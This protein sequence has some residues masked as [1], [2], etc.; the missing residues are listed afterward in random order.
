MN[1]RQISPITAASIAVGLALFSLLHVFSQTI[2]DIITYG[3]FAILM[4]L[5]G[6]GTFVA[7]L[8]K[9]RDLKPPS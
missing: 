4:L 8:R 5:F 2:R 1:P 6:M 7:W 9:R 3:S